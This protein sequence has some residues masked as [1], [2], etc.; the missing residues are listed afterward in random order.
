MMLCL[1]CGH[2]NRCDHFFCTEC[3]RKL[4]E[5]GTVSAELVAM[6]PAKEAR[7]YPLSSSSVYLG[8]TEDNDIIV[9]DDRVSGRHAKL[10]F[11]E[12]QFWIEDLDSTNRTYVNGERITKKSPLK[13]EDLI[14]IGA[15]IFKFKL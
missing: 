14:K 1:N 13:N 7:H 5:S 8:R 12:G 3:G 10:C 6:D 11:E 4:S 9:R 2:R 15:T